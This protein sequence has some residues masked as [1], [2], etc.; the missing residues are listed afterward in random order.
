MIGYFKVKVFSTYHIIYKGV[1][2]VLKILL[3]KVDGLKVPIINLPVS[4]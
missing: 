1:G 4:C 3:T 2:L